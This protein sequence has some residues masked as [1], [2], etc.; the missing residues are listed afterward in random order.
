M[1]LIRPV[2][3]FFRFAA[4]LVITVNALRVG[5]GSV[6]DHPPTEIQ[7]CNPSFL[8]LR[9]YRKGVGEMRAKEEEKEKEKG[10]KRK[11]NTMTMNR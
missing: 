10:G 11:R 6:K 7:V 4:V 8:S 1:K 2:M 3:N 5:P 9:A